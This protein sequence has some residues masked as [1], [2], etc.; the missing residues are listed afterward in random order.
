MSRNKQISQKVAFEGQTFGELIY[1]DYNSASQHVRFTFVFSRGAEFLP[2]YEALDIHFWRSYFS[3]FKGDTAEVT[4]YL[5]VREEVRNPEGLT[6]AWAR[7]ISK[8]AR[9][10]YVEWQQEQLSKERTQAVLACVD[11]LDDIPEGAYI[12]TWGKGRLVHH[13]P[14]V[15]W[16]NPDVY[17]HVEKGAF[18]LGAGPAKLVIEVKDNLIRVI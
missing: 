15:V 10:I 9:R 7:K 12:L 8:T 6:K 18:I 5:R 13:G 11:L 14:L 17:P 1:R 4:I 2:I 3:N 16:V